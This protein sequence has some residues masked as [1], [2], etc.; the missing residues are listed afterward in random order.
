[1]DP[2][3]LMRQA[4]T[5][6]QSMSVPYFVTGSVASMRYGEN[7]LT[8]DI[9]I[10]ADLKSEQAEAFCEKFPEPEFY[11]WLPT[12][13]EAI[14]RQRIFNLLEIKTGLKVD[15]IIV[16]LTDYNIS[17][18]ARRRSLPVRDSQ[19]D[20]ASPEDVIIKKLDYYRKSGSE[21]HIRDI[22]S[23]LKSLKWQLELDY[24]D[25][26]THEFKTYDIWQHVLEKSRSCPEG[27][28]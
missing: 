18:F 9:D 15:L 20:Y 25:R 10:V 7:R 19:I 24:V 26:W 3:S 13:K 1:M 6:L 12:L 8:Q 21:K 4:A 16:P 22:C 28:V 23:M 17:R 27:N 2:T 11:C 5:V 14:A